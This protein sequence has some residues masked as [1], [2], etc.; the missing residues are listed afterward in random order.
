M[1]AATASFEAGEST[2]T[3]LLDV[4]RAALDARTRA[5]EAQASALA[6]ARALDAVRMGLEARELR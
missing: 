5:I 1:E 6:A 4:V 3:D 2:A